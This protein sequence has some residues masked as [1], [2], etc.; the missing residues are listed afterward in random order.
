[1]G[2]IPEL[3]EK[4]LKHFTLTLSVSIILFL[5]II[6]PWLFSYAFPFWP[7]LLAVSLSLLGYIA[8]GSQRRVYIVW[9]KLGLLL[10]RIMTPLILGI[11]YCCL[12]IPMG[13][14]LRITGEVSMN[15]GFD[16]DLTSYRKASKAQ[17]RN[18]LERPF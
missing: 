7:W 10:N 1:M 11:V 16:E 2:N 6:L 5:G 17:K 8:P 3:D 14:I 9:M 4:G 13:F 15:R 18:K 12:I